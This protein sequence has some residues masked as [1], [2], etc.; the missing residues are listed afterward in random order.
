MKFLKLIISSLLLLFYIHTNNLY[1]NIKNEIAIKVENQIITT[2]EIKNKILT[3]LVLS[4]KEINQENINSF[5]EK[6]VNSLIDQKL[7]LKELSKYKIQEDKIQINQYLKSI[8]SNDIEKFKKIFIDNNLDFNLFLEEIKTKLKW[9]KFIY[10]IYSNRI[11]LD[12]SF[13]DK[14]VAMIIKNQKKIEEFNLSEIEV[15]LKKNSS[16]QQ[17]ISDIQKKIFE[18]GFEVAALI[19]SISDTSINKGS[20]GWISKTSLSEKIFDVVSKLAVGDVSDPIIVNDKALFLM[21]KDKKVSNSTNINKEVL[22]KRIKDKKE[23]ELF[24][25]YSVSHLS[26]LKNNTLIEF[27]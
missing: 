14:E 1:G 7:I 25:L 17:L 2:Y 16:D 10:Q 9:R 21:L 5:K 22:K 8:S 23:N 6:S 15:F 11:D 18:D 24:N 20:L 12:E 3:S 19:Y 4:K 26:K 13:L 27:Q